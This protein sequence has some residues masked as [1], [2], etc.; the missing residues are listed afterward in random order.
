MCVA[1]AVIAVQIIW[2]QTNVGK[3]NVSF[4]LSI[5]VSIPSEFC[6]VLATRAIS[7]TAYLFEHWYSFGFPVAL[8][9]IT[10]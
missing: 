3:C 5:S 2:L 6:I 10:R 7:L 8:F 4:L 9:Q 1:I